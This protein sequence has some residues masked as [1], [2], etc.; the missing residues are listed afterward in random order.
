MHFRLLDTNGVHA[1]A[2]NEGFTAK[3]SLCRQNLKNENF[4]SLIGRLRQKVALKSVPHVQ[5]DYFSSLNQSNHWFVTMSLPSSFLK[6]PNILKTVQ[7]ER[8]GSFIYGVLVSN[9]K[10][11]FTVGSRIIFYRHYPVY[12]CNMDI[13]CTV[14]VSSFR[15]IILFKT[16]RVTSRAPASW[17]YCGKIQFS[18]WEWLPARTSIHFEKY[19]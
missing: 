12:D 7:L 14:H 10:N 2:K 5:R 19:R 13:I 4:T 3:G 11:L 9:E 1:K 16:H 8:N 6:L 17:A 15:D 18:C